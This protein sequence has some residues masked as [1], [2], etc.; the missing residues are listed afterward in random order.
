MPDKNNHRT[1]ITIKG[2]YHLLVRIVKLLF[3]VSPGLHLFNLALQLIIALLPLGVLAVIKN[4]IDILTSEKSVFSDVLP[5]IFGLAA[6][7]IVL[8]LANQLS[9]FLNFKIQ[10]LIIDSL[11]IRVLQKTTLIPYPFFETP[12][13]HDS[14]YMA[15]RQAIYK[16]P[17]LISMMTGLVAAFFSITSIFVYF[18][19]LAGPVTLLIIVA[20]LPMAFQKWYGG[21]LSYLIEKKVI[22]LEREAQNYNNILTN[23][24][25][26]KEGRIYHYEKKFIHKFQL[27]RQKIYNKKYGIQLKIA[28]LGFWAEVIEV[29]SVVFILTVLINGALSQ[30]FSLSILVVFIQG[31]QQIKNNSKK[32]FQSFSQLL[33]NQRFVEDLFRFF[34]LEELSQDSITQKGQSN[35]IMLRD[36]SFTYPETKNQ[37][38]TN[39]SMTLNR[40]KIVA[41]VGQNGSG[42]S[43]LM[44]LLANLYQPDS[45]L[46]EGHIHLS[47][48]F[49]F[50]DFGKY[51]LSVKENIIL[52]SEENENKIK[53]A[54]KAAGSTSFIESLP[55]KYATRLG[56][57]FKKGYQL[58]GGEWQK[59]AITRALYE[60][61]DLI[62]LDEPSSALDAGAERNLLNGLSEMAVNSF[63]VLITHRLYHLKKADYIYVLENGRITQEG[64]FNQ[65]IKEGP[66]KVLYDQQR[67]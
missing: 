51:F 33:N 7:Q 43:T 34:D 66:F 35:E 65:L 45:G 44:K 30:D 64:T 15:Q 37:V 60:N 67:L 27:L 12:A 3:T 57:S 55:E 29:I 20:S 6:I 38:L 63:V 4:L 40:G 49:I 22:P 56:R 42:K 19:T 13:Y 5:L 48:R 36:V 59:L 53:Q 18:Y 39:V 52:G 10:N 25:T 9:S 58:S 31:I 62:V 41:I 50:Q 46:I 11:S 23:P 21:K 32:F 8:A 1:K 54:A 17:G 28:R 61:A 16:I 24:E 2:T 47:K 14:L 26:I